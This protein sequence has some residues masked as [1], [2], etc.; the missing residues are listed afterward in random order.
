MNY[1]RL[2]L[3]SVIGIALSNF[4]CTAP[5]EA[6]PLTQFLNDKKESSQS[7]R[8]QFYSPYGLN[9]LFKVHHSVNDA[10]LRLVLT[11]SEE[12]IF[13][14]TSDNFGESVSIELI[15]FQVD[16]KLSYP[17]KSSDIKSCLWSDNEADR[18]TC[19]LNFTHKIDTEKIH[20]FTL[21][22][23]QRLVIDVDLSYLPTQTYQLSPGITWSQTNLH[24]PNFRHLLWNQLTFNRNDPNVYLDLALAHDNPKSLAPVST[25]VS[26]H[27]AIAGVNGGFFNMGKGG[28]LGVAIKDGCVISPHVGR[29]P[30]RSVLAITKDNQ[31][32]VERMKVINNQPLRLNGQAFPPLRL[33]I[34]AGPT[35]LQNGKVHITDTEEELGPKGNDITRACG[36][37]VAAFNENTFMLATVSGDRDSHSQGWKLPT[38]AS[39]LLKKGMTEALNLDGGG[40]VDMSIDS[41]IVANGPQAGTYERPVANALILTD[42]RGANY[43]SQLNLKLPSAM[44]ADGQR[45]EL[46]TLEVKSPSGQPVVDGTVIYLQ[47]RGVKVP[48]SV[49]TKNNKASFPI[50]SL[51]N[52]G[53]A[54]VTAYTPFSQGSSTLT[55][56]SG[57]AGAILARINNYTVLNTEKNTL[58]N[59]LKEELNVY[60]QL[61]NILEAVTEPDTEVIEDD[62]EP[63]TCKLDLDLFLRDKRGGAIAQTTVEVLDDSQKVIATGVSDLRGKVSFKLTIPQT[64]QSLRFKARYF[65][66]LQLN[67]IPTLTFTTLN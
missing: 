28:I 18:Y 67:L 58:K 39:F 46:A 64:C 9:K 56:E 30:A 51:R 41:H 3:I 42:K 12:P 65:K 19:T 11:T 52:P 47:G 40:S 16:K 34:G 27:K 48:Y 26:E 60:P 31:L 62:P 49:T 22:N 43:P 33:A 5:I 14:I 38:M 20:T 50:T 15:N 7:F 54:Q 29:R 53:Q 10:R 2:A 23:P 24:D 57:E 35:L 37:T 25:I 13:Q 59:K 4:F 21:T 17:I 1:K 45:E 8:G 36:R 66:T 44:P 55:L 61:V 63:V 32:S 6:N